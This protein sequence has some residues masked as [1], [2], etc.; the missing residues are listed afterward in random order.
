MQSLW[1]A[2]TRLG[3]QRLSAT[4]ATK[5]RV[6]ADVASPEVAF[7]CLN[8][9]SDSVPRQPIRALLSSTNRQSKEEEKKNHNG[10]AAYHCHELSPS[11]VRL[12]VR[13]LPGPQLQGGGMGKGGP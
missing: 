8:F 10:G 7:K 11:P 4:S 9:G 12:G 1:T 2:A 6:V 5:S 3:D 13:V